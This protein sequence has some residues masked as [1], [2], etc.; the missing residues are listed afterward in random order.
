MDE[1]IKEIEAFARLRKIE[2]QTVIRYAAGQ[3]PGDWRRWKAGGG[4]SVRTAEKIR[5]YIM[6]HSEVTQ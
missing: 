4:C 2:P 3:K 5:E 6:A 1:L